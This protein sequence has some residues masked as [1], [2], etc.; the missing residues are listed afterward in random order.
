MRT[1]NDVD[2]MVRDPAKRRIV[3]G[4]VV[5]GQAASTSQTG[6]F[7]TELLANDANA[8]VFVCDRGIIRIAN[9]G[10]ALGRALQAQRQ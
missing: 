9:S 5:E 10:V 3:G 2:R 6:R 4:K 8:N 7:E 1:C